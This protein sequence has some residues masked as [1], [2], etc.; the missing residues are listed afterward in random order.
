MAPPVSSPFP[1]QVILS[2]DDHGEVM[3]NTA[4]CSLRVM[5]AFQ[6]CVC[7]RGGASWLAP[8]GSARCPVQCP[9]SPITSH[10]GPVPTH[11]SPA[12]P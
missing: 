2:I 1:S 3:F 10:A 9:A 5:Q 11:P 6:V 8:C 4:V 12:G 7:V